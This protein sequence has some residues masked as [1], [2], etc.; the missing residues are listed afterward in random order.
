MVI[1]R[2]R[3][4]VGTIMPSLMSMSCR[5][6]TAVLAAITLVLDHG[7]VVL[8]VQHQQQFRK[9]RKQTSSMLGIAGRGFF[10]VLS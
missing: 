1:V 10:D 6:E 8:L 2:L 5:F 7:Q 9:E 3:S 4:P